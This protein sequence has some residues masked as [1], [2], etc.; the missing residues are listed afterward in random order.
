MPPESNDRLVFIVATKDRPVDLKRMLDSLRAQTRRPDGVI[1]VDASERPVE[2]LV[3]D[4]P[5]LNPV[6]LRAQRPSASAQRNAGI[7][8]M[9]EDIN[10]VGFLD[11][12]ATLE[13]DAVEN[14]L[15][16]W[17]DAPE[18]MGGAAFNYLNPP[19]TTANALKRSRLCRNMG[20][21]SDQPGRVMPS[22]WQTL[23]GTV[24]RNI[25]VD[26]LPST[27]AVWRRDVIDDFT[28]DEFFDGYS[29]LE[30]LDF[31]YS[32]RGKYRL[33]VVAEAGFRHYAST[34]GRRSAYAFGKV[35]AQNRLYFVR[36][37]Q[38][39]IIHCLAGLFVRWMMTLCRAVGRGDPA[40]LG[41]AAGNCVGLL[42]SLKCRVRHNF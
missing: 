27:A 1:V 13:P 29:Y 3:K 21:Y 42:Q 16:F 36:K 23:T 15:N 25:Y 6:Y 32:V 35:E 39:S 34:S 5:E 7:S 9:D 26:W 22:G 14:M 24:E 40:A 30:D 4:F 11:D 10:L 28:F 33:A 37:H 41:R 20:L 38:L 31:S 8:A 17:R 18:D 12:D 19:P 2:G